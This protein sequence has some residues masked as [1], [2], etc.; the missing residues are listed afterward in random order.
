MSI[1]RGRAR[2]WG[3]Y[4]TSSLS[5]TCDRC[6]AWRLRL[7]LLRRELNGPG[8]APAPAPAPALTLSGLPISLKDQ[9]NVKGTEHTMSFVGRIGQVSAHDAV[10]VQ[11]LEQQ[12]AIV[13]CRT[14]MSQGQWFCEGYNNVYKRT[15]NPFNVSFSEPLFPQAFHPSASP[16]TAPASPSRGR[17]AAG[18]PC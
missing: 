17:R 12:G 2:R 6:R 4:S 18:H 8:P 7:R 10:L 9:I 3:R 11:I 1:W 13:Y 14:N 5:V 16:D 15:L